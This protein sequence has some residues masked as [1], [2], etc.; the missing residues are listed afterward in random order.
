MR[1][2]M[3]IG[4]LGAMLLPSRMLSSQA[5][6]RSVNPP[7]HPSA[8]FFFAPARESRAQIRENAREP[9]EERAYDASYAEVYRL[10]CTQAH[11]ASAARMAAADEMVK[12]WRALWDR[13]DPYNAEFHETGAFDLLA[14]LGVA[15]E[16]P[17]AMANDP[18]FVKEWID[19]CNYSCFHLGGD[20][21]DPA[22][23]RFILMQLQL[24]NDVLDHL[25]KEPASEPVLDMLMDAKFTLVD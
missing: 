16:L 22:D 12:R 2:K 21:S 13:Q 3:M 5:T 9:T 8:C 15:H 23:G 14:L 24:R 19:D 25:K 18:E 11:S 1:K 10:W 7:T 20:P 17:A 6:G 4:I